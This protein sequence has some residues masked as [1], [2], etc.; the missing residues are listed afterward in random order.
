VSRKVNGADAW[1]S[2]S[3]L[4][5]GMNGPISISPVDGY[6]APEKLLEIEATAKQ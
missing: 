6:S 3:A 5:P 4:F 1:R 2:F